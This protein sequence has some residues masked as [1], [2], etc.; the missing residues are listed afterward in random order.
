M[1][2]LE[3]SAMPQ[4]EFHVVTI[5]TRGRF[6]RC[7]TS[8]MNRAHRSATASHVYWLSMCAFARS[9]SAAQA[10]SAGVF[11][12]SPHRMSKGVCIRLGPDRAAGRQMSSRRLEAERNGDGRVVGDQIGESGR[13]DRDHRYLGEHRLSDGQTE[14]LAARRMDVGVG[15]GVQ[16]ID[17]GPV[18]VA[19]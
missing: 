11:G 14:S 7:E 16:R 4:R 2:Y 9:A 3:F 10:T 13:R 19:I 15:Q 6:R 17:T 5:A 1:M 8:S 18:Q 12:N